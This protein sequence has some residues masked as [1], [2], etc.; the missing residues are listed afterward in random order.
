M[1]LVS[2]IMAA[3]NAEDFIGSTIE[4]VRS[5]T[6][7]DWELVI[8]NDGSTDKTLAIAE[9]AKRQDDRIQIID[10][11]NQGAHIARNIAFQASKGK[12]IA[13]LD[14]DDRLLPKKL[15]IQVDLL[16]TKREFDVVYGDTWH[17]DEKMNRLILESEKYRGQQHSGNVFEKIVLG[18]LFAVHAALTRR[19]CFEETGLH[20]NEKDLIGDWD[21]WVRVAVSHK[22]FYH[23]DP[24]CEYRL[25]SQMSARKDVASKQLE[26]RLGVVKHIEK[27]PQF[28]KLRPVTKHLFHYANGRFAQKFSLHSAA[29]PFLISSIKYWP[30]S[31]KTY[32]AL[33]FSLIKTLMPKDIK[34]AKS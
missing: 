10:R 5:Q 31:W 23:Q 17:C 2:I 11:L 15:Q 1:P 28:Q 8:V 26:Q 20:R 19:E 27:M 25:H 32:A 6:F 4:S 18:N 7:Q 21:L 3:Y 14:A 16:E 30:F 9:Q 29:I 13:I 24:V 34:N 33:S 12:Y 22:F